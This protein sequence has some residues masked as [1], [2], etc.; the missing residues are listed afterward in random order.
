MSVPSFAIPPQTRRS[1]GNLTLAL[2]V[3]GPTGS[4]Q[5]FW[6]LVALV[7]PQYR[8]VG[9]TGDTGQELLGDLQSSTGGSGGFAVNEK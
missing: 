1:T 7:Q 9:P 3:R 5:P 8:S 4:D 2:E 6:A